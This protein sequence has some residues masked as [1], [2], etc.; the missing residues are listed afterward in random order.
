VRRVAPTTSGAA[1][2]WSRWMPH[3][4]RR[5]GRG[6]GVAEGGCYIKNQ[7][8]DPIGRSAPEPATRFDAWHAE[9]CSPSITLDKVP[10]ARHFNPDDNSP[11]MWALNG[12]AW[13]IVP[14]ACRYY[15]CALWRLVL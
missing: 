5:G 15:L 9:R 11:R 3:P 8:R 4:S 2:R 12:L 10:T 7:V 6:G 1:F 14:L 13:S